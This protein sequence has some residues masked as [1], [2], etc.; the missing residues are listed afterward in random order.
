MNIP[1]P[2][3][4]PTSLLPLPA[5]GKVGG[6]HYIQISNFSIFTHTQQSRL[7]ISVPCLPENASESYSWFTDDRGPTVGG[8]RLTK[9]LP[10]GHFASAAA[11]SPRGWT[12]Q[13]WQ[14]HHTSP[15][16]SAGNVGSP[17]P[18]VHSSWWDLQQHLP[19]K[20]NTRGR[21]LHLRMNGRPGLARSRSAQRVRSAGL[22]PA[23]HTAALTLTEA[24]T[25]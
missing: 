9:I 17:S 19:F 24:Q 4:V 5:P 21:A 13:P 20:V 14:S 8:P 11:R 7:I 18:P 2:R 15:D 22:L 10:N 25:V 1:L 12:H 6:F 16:R 3:P 23:V